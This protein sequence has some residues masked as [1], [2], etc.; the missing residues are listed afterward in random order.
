MKFLTIFLLR[1]SQI[2][3][4]LRRE[5]FSSLLI[6]F[7]SIRVKIHA[8]K[9]SYDTFSWQASGTKIPS[10]VENV[11]WQV[12]VGFSR[13]VYLALLCFSCIYLTYQFHKRLSNLSVCRWYSFIYGAA[14]QSSA[15]IVNV[16]NGDLGRLHEWCNSNGLR[17]N[18]QK[19]LAMCISSDA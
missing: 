14:V 3:K 16:V 11:L 13:A 5:R 18:P 9:N 17:L 8:T 12:R 4:N 19:P 1:F 15:D 7:S 6:L 10:Y 2:A